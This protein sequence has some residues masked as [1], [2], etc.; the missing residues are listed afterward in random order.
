MAATGLLDGKTATTSWWLAPRFRRRFPAIA[1]GD[2]RL[3]INAGPFITAGAGLSHVDL[4][5][6][7]IRRRSPSLAAL[8]ARYLLVDA[9]LSQAP[10][11]LPEHL[12]HQDPLVE[13]FE[14][15]ARHHLDRGFS[16][17]AAAQAVGTSPQTLARRLQATLGK[18]PLG[19]FQEVR[20]EHA[21]H[22]LQTT[23]MSVAQ[24]A[25]AVGYADPVTLATL[26]RRKRGIT[27]RSA[28]RRVE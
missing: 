23:A 2:A 11:A 3:W 14:A 12:A 6:S 22:L 20:M 18:S 15:W 19:F 21:L 26:L 4:A 13:R 10:Y 16:L 8:T 27:V 28:R 1:L 7:L 25:A 17:A 9:R 24:V 5:L